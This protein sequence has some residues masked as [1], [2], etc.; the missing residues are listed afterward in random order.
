M[1]KRRKEGVRGKGRRDQKFVE[2]NLNWERVVEAY[3]AS[4]INDNKV[5][6]KRKA[7]TTNY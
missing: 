4:F 1:P 2:K 6:K 3:K 5:L 7:K